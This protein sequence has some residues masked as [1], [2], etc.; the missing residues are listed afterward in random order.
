MAA[1]LGLVHARELAVVQP[2]DGDVADRAGGGGDG[3]RH[4]AVAGDVGGVDDIE[5][6]Q[7]RPEDREDRRPD[8]PEFPLQAFGR[9]VGAVGQDGRA[10]AERGRGSEPALPQQGACRHGAPVDFDLRV[11][12]WVAERVKA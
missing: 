8:G 5:A 10:L 11:L 1:E 4:R 6:M 12:Q 9:G 7:P 3:R 2:G